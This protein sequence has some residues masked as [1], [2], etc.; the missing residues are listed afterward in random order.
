MSTPVVKKDRKSIAVRAARLQPWERLTVLILHEAM[1][2]A[3]LTYEQMAE[4]LTANGFPMRPKTRLRRGR[5]PMAWGV[6]L[7]RAMGIKEL[8]LRDAA[9][10]LIA[11]RKL[12]P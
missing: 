10:K 8:R 11:P 4:R 7:M 3:E 5:F 1:E 2:S 6:L 9:P 12:K